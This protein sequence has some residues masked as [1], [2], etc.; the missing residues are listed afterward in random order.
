MPP[1]TKVEATEALTI[2]SLRPD[3]LYLQLYRD[4]MASRAEAPTKTTT[5]RKAAIARPARETGLDEQ[6]L[7]GRDATRGNGLSGCVDPVHFWRSSRSR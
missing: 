3:S 4:P 5:P 2:M 7:A 1:T 6:Q